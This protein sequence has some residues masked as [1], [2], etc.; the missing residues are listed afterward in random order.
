MDKKNLLV[1]GGSGFIGSHLVVRALSLGWSV[2]SIGLSQCSLD[3]EE[4]NFVGELDR[5]AY[6]IV[7]LYK[8]IKTGQL[9]A[10]KDV[11]LKPT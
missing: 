9:E 1:V 10:I 6:V 2:V 11:S 7:R 3:R 4:E 8:S 5:G